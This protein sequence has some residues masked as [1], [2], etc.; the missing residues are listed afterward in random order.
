MIKKL[1]ILMLALGICSQG[2]TSED[3]LEE[4]TIGHKRP[5]HSSID[6]P[7]V[8][9]YPDDKPKSKRVLTFN[10]SETQEDWTYELKNIKMNDMA[11]FVDSILVKKGFF[12]IT[13][14]YFDNDILFK[15]YGKQ[16]RRNSIKYMAIHLQYSDISLS[17]NLILTENYTVDLNSIPRLWTIDKIKKQYLV[18]KQTFTLGSWNFITRAIHNANMII[19]NSVFLENPQEFTPLLCLYKNI[20]RYGLENSLHRVS[21][22]SNNDRTY[23]F[24]AL[25][26]NKEEKTKCTE[27]ILS[28]FKDLI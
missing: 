5:A 10:M 27:F 9:M 18:S 4:K 22:V 26:N 8:F 16:E 17:P 11:N 25:Y 13:G 20:R 2:Y 19:D 24:N 15:I 3:I 23:S 1:S 21:I 14:C 7:Q 12:E 28:N 6:V